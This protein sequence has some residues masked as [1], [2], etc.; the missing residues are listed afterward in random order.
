LEK[1]KKKWLAVIDSYLNTVKPKELVIFARQLSVLISADVAVVNALK[2]VAKQTVNINFRRIILEVAS[3][4]E[5]GVKFS[6]ALAHYPKQF[7]NFFVNIIKS[8]EAT[9]RLEEVLLYLADQLEKDY[10]LRSKI[11]GALIYPTF[12]VGGLVVIG[13]LMMIF[14]VPKLTEMLSQTGAELPTST[15]ILKGTSD[16][17][18]YYWW[19][20]LL[21]VIGVVFLGRYVLKT[22]VGRAIF[23]RTML[24]LPVFGKLIRYI[25]IVRF[26]QSF[27]TLLKGGVTVVGSLEISSSM[28]S[29]VVYKNLVLETIEVVN[30]GGSIAK[31]FGQSKY[32]PKMVSQ[33]IATGEDTGKI[34]EV[35]EKIGEFY[36]REIN[37]LINNLMS[38]M[39]PL[40]MVI[41]GLAVGVMIA[42]IIL[43][44]YQ[45]STNM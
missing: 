2:D 31:T 40:I 22:K 3:E 35:L 6:E 18:V 45:I 19:I 41:L 38:L 24:K 12:V 44:M 16:F 21:I 17:L 14:V 7:D 15:R 9:G 20:L 33:M 10:D 36:T 11:K 34:D 29:N 26:V 13:V 39:E 4:V 5:G 43:P 8:G 42:A 28:L 32:M 23:D 1:Q 37:N 25:L 30:D 27:K